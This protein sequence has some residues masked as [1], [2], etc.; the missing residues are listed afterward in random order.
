MR[1]ST[2]DTSVPNGSIEN[3]VCLVS[4]RQASQGETVTV[5]GVRNATIILSVVLQARDAVVEGVCME[6][7]NG[8]VPPSQ[9]PVASSCRFS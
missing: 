7:G 2:P 3:A 6:V 5:R 1:V 9:S 8:S 4:F